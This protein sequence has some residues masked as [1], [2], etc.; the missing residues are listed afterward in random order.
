MTTQE[1]ASKLV[2]LCR[3]GKNDQA[4]DE[5]YAENVTSKEPKGAQMELTEGK[6]AVKDKTLQWEKSIAE[7]HSSTISDPI[8]AD[9]HFSIV[10]DF[11]ATYKEHGRIKMSEICVYEVK[12]GK[13]VADEFFYRMG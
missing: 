8:V 1:V 6:Q 12:D 11:D 10:M 9:H 5:L 7:I 13:I 2:Q 4:I 3:E